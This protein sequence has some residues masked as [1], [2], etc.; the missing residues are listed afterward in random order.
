MG[1][2][3]GRS[4]DATIGKIDSAMVSNRF[5]CLIPREQNFFK[6]AWNMFDF[7]TV[8]GSIVDALVIEFGVR[9]ASARI[10]V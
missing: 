3:V 6:D 4:L 2:Y 7:V 1:K 9:R 8:I 5:S 10:A